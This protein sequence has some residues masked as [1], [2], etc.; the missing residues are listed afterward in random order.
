M[1]GWQHVDVKSGSSFRC[2]YC[3]RDVGPSAG[4]TRE[5]GSPKHRTGEILICPACNRPTFFDQDKT[6]YPGV[7][8]GENVS[9]ITDKEVEDMYSEAR[10]CS[11]VGA[12]TACVMACRKILMNVAVHQEA[13]ENQTFAEYV[14]FLEAKG[15]IPPNGREWVD[16]IRKRGNT[17]THEIKVM[18]ADD[19]TLILDFTTMLL[20]FVYELPSRLPPKKSN[21][22]QS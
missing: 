20:R 19:A 17:A 7:M 4:Y 11:S 22:Q 10:A 12:Y 18:S 1:A 16:E 14:N 5:Q 9:G 15:H 6:Q 13:P 3:H 8:K 2:G 21:S